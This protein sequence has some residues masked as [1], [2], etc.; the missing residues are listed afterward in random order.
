MAVLAEKSAAEKSNLK[1][2]G[3]NG[4]GL[5][6]RKR[7]LFELVLTATETTRKTDQE[8]ATTATEKTTLNQVHSGPKSGS[9]STFAQRLHRSFWRR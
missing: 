5:R 3:G 4:Y 9:T 2:S 8:T 7:H 6:L 1:N